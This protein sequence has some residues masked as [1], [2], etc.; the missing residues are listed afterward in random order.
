[1]K[2]KHLKTKWNFQKNKTYLKIRIETLFWHNNNHNN[3]FSSFYVFF[4]SP[5][6]IHKTKRGN[7]NLKSKTEP[8]KVLKNKGARARKLREVQGSRKRYLKA[9]NNR[10]KRGNEEQQNQERC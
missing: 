1:L 10:T 8:R 5:T 3:N 2:L 9:P 4:G 6:P 7:T